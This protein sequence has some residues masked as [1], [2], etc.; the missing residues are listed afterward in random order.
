M[1]KALILLTDVSKQISPT[2]L[3]QVWIKNEL[4][5]ALNQRKKKIKEQSQQQIT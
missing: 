3:T 2:K 1:V 5:K 4:P